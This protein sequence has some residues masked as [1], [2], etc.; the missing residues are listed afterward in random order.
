MALTDTERGL[1]ASASLLLIFVGV[2]IA[3]GTFYTASANTAERVVDA[4]EEQRDRHEMVA[5]TAVNVTT[6][7][8]DSTNQDLTVR[9]NNTGDTTLAVGAADTLVDGTYVGIDDYE[10][11][12]VAGHDSK[13][14]RP[15]EQLVIED[16]DTVSTFASP[17]GRIKFVT[18]TGVSDTLGVA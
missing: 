11:V 12:T 15:G 4:D 1:T 5:S 9:I 10:R 7:T 2:F 16:R 18:E 3:L 6:A 8:W 14:W 17:P 13:V